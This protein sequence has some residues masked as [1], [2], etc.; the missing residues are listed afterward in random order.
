MKNRKFR[1][2]EI[3]SSEVVEC[4]LCIHKNKCVC[5]TVININCGS[6]KQKAGI[7]K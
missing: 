1:P 5:G 2:K 3:S 4:F 6:F 7:R